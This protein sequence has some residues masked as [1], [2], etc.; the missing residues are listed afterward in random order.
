MVEKQLGEFFADEGYVGISSNL[1][2]FT[3]YFHV[4]HAYVN[5]F[6]V[7]YYKQGLYISKD[8]YMHFKEKIKSFFAQKGASQIHILSLVVCGDKTKARQLCA[9]DAMSWMIDPNENRLMVFEDQVSDFY[10]MRNKLEDFLSFAGQGEGQEEGI[11][12]D[13]QPGRKKYQLPA[14]TTLFI[15]VNILIFF[16][17]I[18][19]G[20]RLYSIGAVGFTEVRKGEYYRIFTSLF[21]HWDFNHLIS[22]MMALYCLGEVVEGS[23]G[24]VWYTVIYMAAGVCGN[25]LSLVNEFFT[26]EYILSVGASGAI[27]GLI[28]A[29]LILVVV[30]RGHFQQ[31]SIWRIAFMLGYSL[32]SGF[33][34]GNINNAAHIGGLICGMA[35]SL[36]GQLPGWFRLW[37]GHMRN[38]GKHE[39]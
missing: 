27:F 14:V 9:D 30:H 39:N 2:E 26:G 33:I 11:K 15:A 12:E 16:L 37:S 5:V 31:F 17:C 35:L 28:G 36:G 1:P 10:G 6:H 32:Y 25:L 21:L 7:I 23:F 3:I 34:E 20:D 38:R 22:N 8:Q 13:F 4:E 19:V 29:L 24:P 18:C